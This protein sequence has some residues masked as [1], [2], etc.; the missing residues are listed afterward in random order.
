MCNQSV[1]MK[2]FSFIHSFNKSKEYF[3][4]IVYSFKLAASFI[5]NNKINKEDLIRRNSALNGLH[6]NNIMII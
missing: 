5:K 3:T 2:Y 6:S 1:K 4:C